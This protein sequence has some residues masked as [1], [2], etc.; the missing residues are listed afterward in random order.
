MKNFD[1]RQGDV[2][3]EF[4]KGAKTNLAYNCLDANINKGLGDKPAIIFESDEGFREEEE[5]RNAHVF[6]IER[7]ER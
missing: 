1:A 6:T 4:F 3:I 5:V 2:N 7:Q